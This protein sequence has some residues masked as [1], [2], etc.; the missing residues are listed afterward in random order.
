MSRIVFA[1]LS[2][3]ATLLAATGATAQDQNQDK[4]FKD[5]Y[6]DRYGSSQPL[7]LITVV[8]G[9]TGQENNGCTTIGSLT[10]AINVE[11]GWPFDAA[12]RADVEGQVFSS[13]NRRFVFYRAEAIKASS[14]AFM[15]R[16]EDGCKLLRAGKPAYVEDRT[17]QIRAGR[18]GQ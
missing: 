1:L 17:G 4:L 10:G 9:I 12:H 18:P 15:K 14:F 2:V 11:N 3:G 6:D 16:Y 7:I 13:E 5:A 8:N